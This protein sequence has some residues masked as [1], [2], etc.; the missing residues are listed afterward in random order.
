MD[1]LEN[2]K[3]SI[4]PS[5]STERVPSSTFRYS[6]H[7]TTNSDIWWMIWNNICSIRNFSMLSI[8]KHSR[9]GV[10]I[11][12]S[13][14]S[15]IDSKIEVVI[16]KD[17]NYKWRDGRMEKRREQREKR[18]SDSR[19]DTKLRDIKWWNL[20]SGELA[21]KH[22]DQ[23]KFNIFISHTVCRLIATTLLNAS[24]SSASH[25][26]SHDITPHRRV[27]RCK[28]IICRALYNHMRDGKR[29]RWTLWTQ[30]LCSTHNR[31]LHSDSVVFSV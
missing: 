20:R 1:S 11:G 24:P 15:T 13:T 5:F 2:S 14:A 3:L 12:T 31:A 10:S 4:F 28:F 19:V 9:A 22:G 27:L 26:F 18:S 7:P 30:F 21:S 29:R 6:S 17:E 23:G 16:V 25:L 8:I